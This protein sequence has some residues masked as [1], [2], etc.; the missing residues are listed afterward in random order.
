MII[1]MMIYSRLTEACLKWFL[2][3]SQPGTVQMD[4]QKAPCGTSGDTI[5]EIPRF[6]NMVEGSKLQI[7]HGTYYT[8]VR[9]EAKDRTVVSVLSL[10]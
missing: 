2:Y 9:D 7:M 8:A 5:R 6:W 10:Y 3:S 1:L 4:L